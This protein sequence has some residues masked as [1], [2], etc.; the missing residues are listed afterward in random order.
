MRIESAISTFVDNS[1]IAALPVMVVS[2][3][4]AAS[5]MWRRLTDIEAS[6]PRGFRAAVLR[7]QTIAAAGSVGD[8]ACAGD[9]CRG[10][11]GSRCSICATQFVGTA[12][13]SYTS[14][15]AFAAT[16]LDGSSLGR[17]WQFSL[18]RG[19]GAHGRCTQWGPLS[20]LVLVQALGDAAYPFHIS[21]IVLQFVWFGA[22]AGL[23]LSVN[24]RRYVATY[25]RLSSS[26]YALLLGYSFNTISCRSA[27]ISLT[28]QTTVAICRPLKGSDVRFCYSEVESP[29]ANQLRDW[30]SQT[31]VAVAPFGD[32]VRQVATYRVT[33]SNV[34][35]SAVVTLYPITEPQLA[36]AP[37]R[38]TRL[39]C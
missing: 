23:A 1:A 17:P 10:Q 30:T 36:M 37:D 6:A 15:I 27:P 3:F 8:G 9:D 34:A 26:P 11:Y 33:P 25:L 39:R 7:S 18:R 12:V 31:L 28:R 4:V 19:M 24:A 32:S 20:S 21:F 16:P 22:L 29:I 38:S 35:S 13:V 5:L 2:A 14:A